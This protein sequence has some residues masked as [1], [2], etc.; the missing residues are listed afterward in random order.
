MLPKDKRRAGKA[1]L[2]D[3]RDAWLYSMIGLHPPSFTKE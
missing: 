3:V 2:E 1:A